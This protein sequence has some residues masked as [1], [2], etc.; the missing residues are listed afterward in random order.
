LRFG[1]D[2]DAINSYFGGFVSSLA[3][4]YAASVLLEFR[5]IP[6]FLSHSIAFWVFR[7]AISDTP[8]QEFAS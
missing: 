8:S 3:E 6:D 5:T 7:E 1:Y 2:L 4:K